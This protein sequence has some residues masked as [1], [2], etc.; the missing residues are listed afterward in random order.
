MPINKKR[1]C[2][3]GYGILMLL[4]LGLIYGWS[5]FVAPLEAEFGWARS[6]TSLTFTI[7]ISCFC[8]GGL[9]GSFCTRKW[10]VRPTLFLSAGLLLLGFLGASRI[11]TLPG[12]YFSYGVGC[13]L[14]VGIG[15]NVLLNVMNQ[16]FPDKPGFVSG[17]LLMGFG[18]GGM[19]LGS[20][21]TALMGAM[22]W[23]NTFV[24]FGAL[25]FAVVLAGGFFIHLPRAGAA[26]PQSAA[27]KRAASQ[28]QLE[29]APG[30]MLRRPSFWFYTLWCILLP[31]GG[32]MFIGNAAPICT[33][34]GADAALAAFGAGFLSVSNGAGRVLFGMLYD[35]QGRKLT[36]LLITAAFL[37]AAGLFLL[38]YGQSSMV[39]LF[40]AFLLTG[41]AYGGGPTVNAA[42]LQDFYGRQH[43]A[44]NLSVLNLSLMAASFA[45]P[46]AAAAIQTATGSYAGIAYLA[47]ALGVGGMGA[48]ALIKRP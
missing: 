7:S 34:L 12:I 44:A 35:K 31:A 11:S 41:L 37:A 1:Y 2:L 42:F 19:I 32:L 9:L 13:G 22:G 26:L 21:A 30:G 38:A 10:G 48:M 40:I 6:Q 16:W 23:R 28:G 27:K 5:I 43:F 14:G 17:M 36:M 8:L 46:P 18:C 45:G 4:C 39:A 3:L 47:L 15:Y 29:L 20:L 25:F 24:L 33:Q